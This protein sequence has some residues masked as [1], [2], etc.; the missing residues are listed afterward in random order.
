VETLAC[1]KRLCGITMIC[2]GPDSVDTVLTEAVAGLTPAPVPGTRMSTILFVRP[3]VFSSR[4]V[5]T[6]EVVF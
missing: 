2:C 1:W 6:C 3:P 5:M 4:N